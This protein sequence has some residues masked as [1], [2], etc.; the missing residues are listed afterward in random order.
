LKPG[1]TLIEMLVAMVI[2]ATAG[3]IVSTSVSNI[4]FQTWSIE[5][6][7]IA[8]WVA[9]DYLTELRL[10]RRAKPEELRTGRD[11]IRIENGGRRW[12]LRSEAMT[13]G[14]PWVNRVEV[15]V[16]ELDVDGKVVGPLDHQAAFVGRY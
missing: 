16:F 15:E 8:H 3:I 14:H 7:Q 9:E 13:T 6:R 5:R 10:A 1:F 2:L 11:T 4:S 12:E